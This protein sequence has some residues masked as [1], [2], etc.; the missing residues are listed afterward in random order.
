[1]SSLTGVSNQVARD[2]CIPVGLNIHFIVPKFH[3]FFAF[4]VL[5]NSCVFNVIVFLEFTIVFNPT[6]G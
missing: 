4:G 5:Y 2:S 1:M 3:F 6:I